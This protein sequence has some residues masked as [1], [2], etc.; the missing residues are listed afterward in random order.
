MARRGAEFEG[1]HERSD[2]TTLAAVLLEDGTFDRVEMWTPVD[3]VMHVEGLEVDVEQDHCV[4]VP[5]ADYDLMLA[6]AER[7][8]QTT[9]GMEEIDD[10]RHVRVPMGSVVMSA[11][12]LLSQLRKAK[13]HTFNALMRYVWS[14][15]SNLWSAMRNWLAITHKIA[16]QF[17]QGMSGQDIGKLLGV[18]RAAFNKTEIKLVIEYLESWGVRGGT[19]GGSKPV[20]HRELKS[21]QMM[22]RRHHAEDYESDKKE[23]EELVM[24]PEQKQR[25]KGMREDAERRRMAALCGVEPHEIDLEKT[26]IHDGSER[27]AK[28]HNNNRRA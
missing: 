23:P 9:P 18:C 14:N 19:A 10:T 20:G 5:V 12:D 28:N 21:A 16:P 1:L 3:E 27:R 6:C 26:R 11:E 7:L 24:T 25:A 22:G 8:A 4:M 2:A 13:Q 15:S 17:I